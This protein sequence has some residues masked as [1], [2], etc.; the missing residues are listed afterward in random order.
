MPQLVLTCETS[1]PRNLILSNDAG[2]LRLID[3]KLV[4]PPLLDFLTHV[5]DNE[6][7]GLRQLNVTK[8]TFYNVNSSRDTTGEM[9]LA[10]EG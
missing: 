1:N 7:C 2:S 8:Q 4:S 10:F 6:Q 5:C 3:Y 9:L